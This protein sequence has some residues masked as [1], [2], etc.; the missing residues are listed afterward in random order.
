MVARLARL[1]G[2][3]LLTLAVF[4]VA[5]LIV[6]PRA[7]GS[8]SYS[9][10]TNSMAP[11]Y[12]PG[13]FLVVRPAAFGELKVGDV[14]TYQIKSGEPAVVTHRIVGLGFLQTGEKVLTT[15][16]DNNDTADPGTVREVQIR[17]KLFYA[18]PYVGYVANALGTADRS[19]WLMAGAFALI[20]Y[21]GFTVVR[22]ARDRGARDRG[23][24]DTG[25]K[26]ERKVRT[27]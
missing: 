26:A 5:V 6:V 10:L 17:G 12:A 20:A 4:A 11:K 8:Q 16:G 19:L 18:V 25:S 27:A 2:V 21:G 7:S 9:V 3:A 24:Q 14:V 15:K 1:A 22:G 23:A 13:T